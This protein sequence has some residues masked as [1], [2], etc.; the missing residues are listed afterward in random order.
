MS[1]HE[2]IYLDAA[3]PLDQLVKLVRSATGAVVVDDEKDGLIIC[4]AHGQPFSVS[5]SL[6]IPGESLIVA[7]VGH[8]QALFD[9]LVAADSTM[10]LRLTDEVDNTLD[11]RPEPPRQAN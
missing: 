11:E 8:G 1:D 5:E 3:P 9:D 10:G 6:L 7:Q 2:Y 4:T